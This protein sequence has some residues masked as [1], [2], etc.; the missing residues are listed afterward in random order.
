MRSDKLTPAADLFEAAAAQKIREAEA[1]RWAA[2]RACETAPRGR[3]TYRRH[4]AMDATHD[5]LRAEV[6]L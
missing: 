4:K 2:L 1:I 5:A 3:V 6:R